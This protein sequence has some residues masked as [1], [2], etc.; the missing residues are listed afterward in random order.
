L[1][2]LVIGARG[3]VGERVARAARS[4]YAVVEADLV[5]AGGAEEIPVDVTSDDSV[6]R[7]FDAVKPAIVVHAAAIADIDRCEREAA[8]A[9]GVNR[10]G[11]IRVA[12][13][14][15]AAGARMVFLSTAAVFDGTWHGYAE[16]DPVNPLSVYGRTKA[17]AEEGL[18]AELPEAVIIRPALVVGFSSRAGTNALLNRLAGALEAGKQV[19][20]PEDESRNPIDAV[21]LSEA[22]LKLAETAEARG[23]FHI[24]ATA[25]ISRFEMSRRLAVL[26]GFAPELV[27]RQA[28]A[29]AGRAPR[30]ADHFLLTGKICAVAGMRMPGCDEVLERCRDEF[31]EGSSR[32]GV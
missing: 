31:T 20:V 6:A 12:R 3:F 8:L 24:G 11:A 16:D 7:V 9:D 25:A 13:A 15:R 5:A 1:R 4:R 14:C 2:V 23:V 22:I 32:A 10:G 28:G 27:V 29:P 21:T 18:L 26:W 30:G 17:A 19:A